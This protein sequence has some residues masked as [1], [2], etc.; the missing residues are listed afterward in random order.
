M[1][2]ETIVKNKKEIN[3]RDQILLFIIK[4]IGSPWSPFGGEINSKARKLEK[5]FEKYLN[6]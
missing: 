1:P 4:V 5:E 3:I 6:E 2:L